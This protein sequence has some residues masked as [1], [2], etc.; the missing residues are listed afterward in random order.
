MNA[1]TNIVLRAIKNTEESVNEAMNLMFNAQKCI[2]SLNDLFGTAL[3]HADYVVTDE[4]V[5][6]FEIGNGTGY[7]DPLVHAVF[8]DDAAQP[9]PD[10]SSVAIADVKTKRRLYLIVLAKGKNVIVHDHHS[11]SG[12][13][14]IRLAKTG[15]PETRLFNMDPVW[16]TGVTADL[17]N[18]ANLFGFEINRREETPT[19]YVPRWKSDNWFKQMGQ[20]LNIAPPRYAPLLDDGDAE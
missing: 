18:A 9:V 3:V 6:R 20:F 15:G 19:V 1:T 10:F 7:Y 12:A 11:P 4:A 14:D 2:T 13:D 8:L 17:I 16:H 5:G